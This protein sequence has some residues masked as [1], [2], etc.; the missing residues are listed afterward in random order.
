M[1]KKK[2]GHRSYRWDNRLIHVM[3]EEGQPPHMGEI[4]RVGERNDSD[5]SGLQKLPKGLR[6]QAEKIAYGYVRHKP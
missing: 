2:K 3:R 1:A 5:V 6:E 4:L